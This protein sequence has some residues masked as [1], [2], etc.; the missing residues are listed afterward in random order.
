MISADKWMMPF[1]KYKNR[2]L[3]ALPRS[4]LIW[5]KSLPDLK[6]PLRS[7]VEE[8]LDDKTRGQ[9]DP[10][11]KTCVNCSIRAYTF[12]TKC[13]YCGG[14]LES[15]QP[16]IQEDSYGLEPEPESGQ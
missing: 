9:A 10:K 2:I 3:G 6:D 4:Y 11:D 5:L 13:K 7:K 14:K 16:L 12:V 8:V 15:T 1:G